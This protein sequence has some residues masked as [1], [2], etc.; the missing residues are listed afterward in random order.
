MIRQ[1]DCCLIELIIER[2]RIQ[3]AAMHRSPTDGVSDLELFTSEGPEAILTKRDRDCD[4][5]IVADTNICLFNQTDGV[6]PVD[7]LSDAGFLALNGTRPTR[8]TETSESL[9][10]TVFVRQKHSYRHAV[11]I[12][13][14]RGISD[15]CAIDVHML[16]KSEIERAH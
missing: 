10:D 14:S 13:D 11:S 4:C 7:T 3:L 16:L 1:R 9:I 6:L 12:S 5:M 8:V 15:H 2:R